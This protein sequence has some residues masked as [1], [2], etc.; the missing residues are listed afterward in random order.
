MAKYSQFV[1]LLIRVI[2]LMHGLVLV[3]TFTT[4]L[5]A[6]TTRNPLGCRGM[7]WRRSWGRGALTAPEIQVLVLGFPWALC[8]DDGDDRRCERIRCRSK[9]RLLAMGSGRRRRKD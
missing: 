3:G 1:L 6:L 9:N 5:V 4:A 2:L 8:R 7:Q